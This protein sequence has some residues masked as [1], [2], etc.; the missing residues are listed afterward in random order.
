MRNDPAVFFLIPDCFKTHKMCERGV[1][2]DQ[3]SLCHLPDN[4]KIQETYHKAVR[5][6]SFSLQFVP[7][8]F[9]VLQEMWCEKFDDNDYFIRSR[10]AHQKRKAQKAN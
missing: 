7:D 10:N 3:W 4:F 9:V 2:V 5:N 8:W 6:Y 1:E